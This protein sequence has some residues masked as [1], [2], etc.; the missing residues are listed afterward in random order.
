VVKHST[1]FYRIV[2]GEEKRLVTLTP[3]FARGGFF[4][5]LVGRNLERRIRYQNVPLIWL[6]GGWTQS[7]GGVEL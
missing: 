4:A 2:K 7:R 5:E 3:G 1:L 6:F